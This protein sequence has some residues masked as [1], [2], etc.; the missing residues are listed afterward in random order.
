MDGN[1]GEIPRAETG[2]QEVVAVRVLRL[3][4]VS[5]RAVLDPN[6]AESRN[7]QNGHFTFRP[8]TSRYM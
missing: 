4:G 6:R 7:V 5:S 8:H 2:A 3:E 1:R